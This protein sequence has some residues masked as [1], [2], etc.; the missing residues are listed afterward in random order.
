[1]EALLSERATKEGFVLLTAVSY[2]YCEYLLN[3][4]CNLERLRKSFQHMVIA[5]LDKEMYDW[6]ALR[7]LPVFLPSSQ[8]N[9]NNTTVSSGYDYGSQNFRAITKLKS[10]SALEVM[11]VGYSVVYSDVDITWF[12]DPFESLR[13]Y[14]MKNSTALMI[15]SNAPY[16]PHLADLKE[17]F[18]PHDSVAG[19]QNEQVSNGFRRINSGMYVAPNSALMR[20]AFAEIASTA[21]VGKLSEEPY[22]YGVLCYKLP[23]RHTVGGMVVS[24]V[25]D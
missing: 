7:G 14:T 6:G 17:K 18:R 16:A 5:A 24:F 10:R 12:Q 4:I 20:I 13:P 3:L 23:S 1:M 22:F 21:A 19:V 2:N 25:L 11:N 9:D 15:Q 8:L